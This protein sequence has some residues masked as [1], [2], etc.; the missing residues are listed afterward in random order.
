MHTLVGGCVNNDEEY[1]SVDIRAIV[2]AAVTKL[3]ETGRPVHFHEITDT[4]FRMSEESGDSK[5]QEL[6]KQ[7]IG[8]FARKMH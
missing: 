1:I 3:I 6:C 2:G 4:L 8:F 5:V 7:A